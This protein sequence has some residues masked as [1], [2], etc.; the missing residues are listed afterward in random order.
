MPAS[1]S[2]YYIFYQ[3][4]LSEKTLQLIG[5]KLTAAL[6]IEGQF[7]KEGLMAMTSGEDMS[8][9]L[10][11]ALVDGL[12]G[13]GV[14]QIWKS[15]N[16][17]NKRPGQPQQTI[18]PV[19]ENKK[20]EQERTEPIEEIRDVPLD[21]ERVVFVDFVTFLGRRKKVERKAMKAQELDQAIEGT[22]TVA[23]L[24]LFG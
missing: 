16:E 20:D 1:E 11:K 12:E 17:A 2:A 18:E 19:E 4:T 23:Q 22:K 14:E 7:S 9:A 5:S 24:A 13:E 3:D 15:I 10:A 6:S 21:P 8:V